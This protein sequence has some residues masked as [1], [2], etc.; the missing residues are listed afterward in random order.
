MG[1]SLQHVLWY[2]YADEG[3]DTLNRIV[4]GDDSRVRHY[5][6]ELKRASVQ[7]K[8]PSSPSTR[9]FKVTSTPSDGKVKLTVFWYSQGVMLTHFQMRG[10]NVNSV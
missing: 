3:E 4:T 6:P 10:G 5:Q 1:L 9:K 7:R 2:G 8:H